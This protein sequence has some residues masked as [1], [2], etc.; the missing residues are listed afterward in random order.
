M[1]FFEYAWNSSN[2]D[3]CA[4]EPPNAAELKGAGVFWCAAPYTG[5]TRCQAMT[6]YQADLRRRSEQQAQT[7]ADLTGWDVNHI[8]QRMGE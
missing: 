5:T 1:V 3:P 4:G 7:L 2:C 6:S 8:R